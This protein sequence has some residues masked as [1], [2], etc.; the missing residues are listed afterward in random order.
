[1][2]NYEKLSLDNQI[3]LALECGILLMSFKEKQKNISTTRILIWMFNFYVEIEVKQDNKFRVISQNAIVYPRFDT[4]DKFN[5][6]IC[7]NDLTNKLPKY[8]NN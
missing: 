6:R 7:I 1:M 8:K 3:E 5:E 4:L 2:K